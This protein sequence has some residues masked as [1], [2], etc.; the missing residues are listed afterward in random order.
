MKKNK[1]YIMAEMLLT[2]C[3]LCA[4][5]GGGKEQTE[6]ATGQ[7]ETIL[8]TE[9]LSCY[10]HAP[11]EGW[12][13]DLEN[14]WQLCDCGEKMNEGAHTVTD[15][16]CT[17]CG[18]EIIPFDDGTGQLSITDDKGNCV[19]YGLY[20]EDG[21]MM[22]GSEFEYGEDG[23]WMLEK[24]LEGDRL[25]AEQKFLLE[26]DMQ[27]VVKYVTYNEDGSYAV[28][29]YDRYGN[30]TLEGSY[31]AAGNAE[32]ERSY[33][34]EYDADG[35]RTLRLTYE[36]GRL[37][38]EMEFVFGQDEDG[39]S[40]SQSG[41]T[42]TYHEDGT[43]TVTDNDLAATW[44]SE[45]TYDAQGNVVE[46]IRYEYLYDDNGESVGS[47]GYRNGDLFVEVHNIVNEDGEATGLLWTDYN[48][49]GSKTVKEYNAEFDLIKETVCDADGNV[50]SEE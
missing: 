7:K 32:Y 35:N 19:R 27:T 44:S 15:F 39:N 18:A 5:C 17:V 48:E 9:V 37:I 13:C 43:K 12:H 11:M 23:T 16:V 20:D 25:V 33:E 8:P 40:W 46:D 31:D 29:E 45:I 41:K 4:A 24:Q 47:K 22:Y 50:I 21:S 10:A 2:I 36:N 3:L 14:H 28:T 42:T 34:N 49:D 6:P 38:E 1:L 30:D 26:E